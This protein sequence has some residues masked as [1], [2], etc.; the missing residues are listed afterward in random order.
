[1]RSGDDCEY[2]HG[3]RRGPS[4]L[5]Q[6]LIIS[7]RST[8]YVADLELAAIGHLHDV[9]P[10]VLIQIKDGNARSEIS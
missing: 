10:I 2:R 7:I 6:D 9:G 8:G 4:K 1:M 3:L 5:A